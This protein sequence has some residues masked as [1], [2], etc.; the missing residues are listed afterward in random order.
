MSA[1]LSPGRFFGASQRIATVGAVRLTELLH[2]S[3]RVPPRHGHEAAYCSWLVDGQYREQWG[4]RAVTYTN[5]TAVM[6]PYGFAHQDEIGPAGA[7]F[8]CVEFDSTWP[9]R[10]GD[11]CHRPWHEPSQLGPD[12]VLAM[13]R[14]HR[15][16][17]LEGPL[18]EARVEGL[19][20]ELLA[21]IQAARWLDTCRP[22]WLDTVLECVHDSVDA[23]LRVSTVAA[24]VS[25]HPVHVARAFRRWTGQ[26]LGELHLRLR[27][28]RATVLMREPDRPLA[29]IAVACGF[30]D[31]SHLTRGFRRVMGVTPG[32]FRRQRS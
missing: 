9:A 5:A 21:A 28:E 3:R 24:A 10:V 13:R 8:L 6:H 31:Q 26:S 7:R 30:S 16:L 15:E 1:P 4:R 29:D 32:A 18:D 19:V 14:L 20:L 27:V 11:E 12:G 25:R 23:P 22:P 2:P 17:Q